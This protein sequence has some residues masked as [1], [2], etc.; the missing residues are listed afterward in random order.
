MKVESINR[1]FASS[2]PHKK[3]VQPNFKGG[4][5]TLTEQI[6]NALPG[7]KAITKSVG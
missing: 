5:G 6:T 1:N 4:L 2:N 7:R 3:N